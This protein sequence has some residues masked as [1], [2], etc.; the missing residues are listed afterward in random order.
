MNKKPIAEPHRLVRVLREWS[1]K[2]PQGMR[3]LR[4]SKS[5]NP[6]GFYALYPVA[7]ESEKNFFLPPR[8]SLYLSTTSEQDPMV[9]AKS[10]DKS[11]TCVHL[12]SWYIDSP[13]RKKDYFCQLLEDAKYTLRKM[14]ADFS[15]LC[16]IYTLPLHPADEPLASAMGFQKISQDS[17]ISI[18]WMYLPLDNYLA[19]DI[20]KAASIL[21]FE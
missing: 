6:V 13:Y 14:Q 17:Q 1:E 19:L 4:C 20:Y 5:H 18:C 21:K 7:R 9:M 12:R 2:Y 11:C 3:V 15:N 16:D 10:G 8:K